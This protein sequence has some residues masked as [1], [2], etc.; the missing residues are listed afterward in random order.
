[1]INSVESSAYILH[2]VKHHLRIDDALD[3][4][5]EHAIGGILGLL[6]NGLF[7]STDIIALDGVNTSV[8]GGWIDGHWK[9]FGIQLA[10][11][12]ACCSYVF[13]VTAIIAKVIDIIPGL[14]LRAS[15]DGEVAGMDEDQVR[16]SSIC[17]PF[18]LTN[19]TVHRRL[20]NL[21]KTSLKFDEI[22]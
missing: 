1:M 14:G 9:Q 10:Y 17:S 11:V 5:A 6:A 18:V 7:G 12:C 16:D 22:I 21:L 13:V 8:P 2:T 4:F 19:L 20:E 15:Q 3:L